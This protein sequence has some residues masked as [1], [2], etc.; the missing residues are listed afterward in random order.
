[1]PV[2]EIEPAVRLST[3]KELAASCRRIIASTE[4]EKGEL[5]KLYGADPSRIAVIPCGVNLNLFQP[6]DKDAARQQL[7]L[8]QQKKI[9]LFVGRLEPLKGLENVIRA[10]GLLNE[11]EVQLLIIGGDDRSQPEVDR[12]TGLA[13]ELGLGGKVE[14]LGTVPQAELSAYYSSA[15]IS[16]V[17]SY[18]ESF[19]LVI[20][21]SMACGTPVVS[22]M[23]GVAP[24]VIRSGLNGY[25]SADNQPANLAEGIR[26]V[27]VP[28]NYLDPGLI[29]RSVACFSW[30]AVAGTVAEEYRCI[31]QP[32]LT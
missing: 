13:S 16:V 29:R 19:C 24:A 22:T 2:G 28:G 23:V 15:D 25:V 4:Q 14:F 27:L 18:Y 31:Q 17:A 21:E 11:P 26:A 30:P 8:A 7:G 5:V 10:A 32:V 20:L 9:L 12:L 3:E 6:Y 1:L